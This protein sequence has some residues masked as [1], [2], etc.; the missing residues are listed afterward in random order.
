MLCEQHTSHVT[1]SHFSH[2]I[3]RNERGSSRKFGVRTSHSHASS[4]CA[5]VV[6]LILFDL[7]HFPLFAVYLLSYHLVFLLGHQLHLPRCGGQIPCALSANEDLG[8]LAEYDP[9]HKLMSPN[10]RILISRM[11][12]SL[13][14]S[15]MTSPSGWR[16]L[17]HCNTQ[18]SRRICMS[19]EYDGL[20]HSAWLS[21]L[22]SSL[23]SSV[24]HRTGRSV[25]GQFD[26]QIF[27]R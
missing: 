6:C 3:T 21:S 9:S 13:T 20:L 24:G 4:P 1:F 2:L 16:S 8:T 11:G 22:S 25:V 26:S 27:K 18:E 15:T 5:H 19:L 12:P 10:R 14:S 17:H 23:S 7:L